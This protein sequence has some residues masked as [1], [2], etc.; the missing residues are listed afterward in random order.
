VCTAKLIDADL[1]ANRPWLATE[2]VEGPTLLAYVREHG[3]IPRARLDALALGLLDALHA[4]HGAGVVHR[5]LTPS[6]VLLS[7]TG[8]KVVDFGVAHPMDGTA[9]TMIGAVIGTPAW[10]APEQVHGLHP[11]AATDVFAWGS[12]IA[13]AGLGR[14]VFGEGRPEV[15]LPRI[16]NDEPDLGDLDEPLRSLV[17]QCLRKDPS[18]RPT[19]EDVVARLVDRDAPT[20]F[21]TVT[22][23]TLVDDQTIPVP[24]PT[25]VSRGRRRRSSGSV[26]AGSGVAVLVVVAAL[27]LAVATRGLQQDSAAPTRAATTHPALTTTTPAPPSAAATTP[28]TTTLPSASE[29]PSGTSAGSP[30]STTPDFTTQLGSSVSSLYQ[31][32]QTNTGYSPSGTTPLYTP[33]RAF[34]PPAG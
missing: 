24:L 6:N 28:T 3:A 32:G 22:E 34:S 15:L 30:A 31:A 9:I 21:G 19:I 12:V 1:D 14:S 5:D 10:M 2:F 20:Q 29:P 18:S 17:R 8:P 7:P 23:T 16:V 26:R 11:T 33:L 4:I 25:S 27:V 13:Y